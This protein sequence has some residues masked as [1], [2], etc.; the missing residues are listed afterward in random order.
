M[1]FNDIPNLANEHVDAIN[2]QIDNVQEQ[3][4]DKLGAHGDTVNRGVDAAQE[5]F[6][7]GD[8]QEAAENQ[9]MGGQL[10]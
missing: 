6:L 10:A 5:K 4:G 9:T 8:V 1:G 7:T 2:E 3:H